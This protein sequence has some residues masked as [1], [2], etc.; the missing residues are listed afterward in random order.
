MQQSSTHHHHIESMLQLHLILKPNHH[1]YRCTEMQL[2]SVY[3]TLKGQEVKVLKENITR[4]LYFGLR[5][6]WCDFIEE[7]RV[8]DNGYTMW[9]YFSSPSSRRSVA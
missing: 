5:L 4:P 3:Y 2:Q 1:K 7:R 9:K 8:S 6:A